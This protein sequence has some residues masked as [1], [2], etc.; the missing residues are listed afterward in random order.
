MKTNSVGVLGYGEIGQAI[1][2]F[3]KNPKIKDLKRDDGLLGVDVLHVC[4]PWSDKFVAIVKKEIAAIKPKLVIIHS[5]V[6]PGTTKKIGGNVVHS[7]VRGVHP[8]L[9]EGIKTF[10]KYIGADQEKIGKA[11]QKHLESLSIKTKLITP[12]MA[13]EMGKILDTTY[14]GV[15][16]AWHGEMYEICKK[17]KLD[18]QQVVTDFNNTYNEGYTKL[19]KKHFV[20]PVLYPPQF[21]KPKHCIVPN[22]TILKKYYQS[23]VFQLLLKK[24]RDKL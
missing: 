12:A 24:Y 3:Y 9:H 20:R 21:G 4:I 1:A 14:Y 16:I 7:P 8:N 11:V 15:V 23:P 19:G 2:K 17:F 5:T 18:F 22:A 13:T 10:V 6:A